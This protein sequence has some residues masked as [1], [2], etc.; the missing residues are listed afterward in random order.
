MSRK[1]RSRIMAAIRST[2]TKPERLLRCALWQDG[3]RGY[4]CQWRGPGG[5]IDIA[6][7]RWKVAVFVDGCFWHGH[8]SKWQPGRWTGYWDEKIKRNIARDERQ[9]RALADAGWTV[10]RVWDFEVEHDPVGSA[11]RVLVA[12]D[13]ARKAAA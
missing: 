6:F 13:A 3:A 2:D 4:R 1:G 5:R 10:I 11:R 12:L 8:P 7:T 9:N